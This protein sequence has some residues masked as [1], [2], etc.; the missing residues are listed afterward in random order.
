MNQ[1]LMNRIDW[2]GKK[3]LVVEDDR[4]SAIFLAKILEKVHA[5]VLLTASGK[6][7]VDICRND[8]NID[9]V[10][11]DM[12][13]PEMDGYAATR[14]IKKMRPSLPV[15]AQTAYVLDEDRNKCIQA[16]CDA[17]ISKPINTSDLLHT[18]GNWIG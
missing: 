12:Q 15:F 2:T 1:E 6:E 5:D 8:G 14:K 3:I 16:G 7:A 13:V 18:I 11:M 9:L 17:F 10:L 4:A